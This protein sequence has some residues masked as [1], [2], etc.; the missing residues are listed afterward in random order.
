MRLPVTSYH[1]GYS[2]DRRGNSTGVKSH[3]LLPIPRWEV[4]TYHY[5]HH[6]A[7]CFA[8]DHPRGRIRQGPYPIIS[9][10]RPYPP[11]LDP[12]STWPRPSLDLP[13]VSRYFHR[14]VPYITM[15]SRDGWPFLG[16]VA[17]ATSTGIDKTSR[18]PRRPGLLLPYKRAGQGSIRG[19]HGRTKQDTSQKPSANKQRHITHR[20]TSQAIS[21]VLSLFL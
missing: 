20:S 6:T 12:S 4:K 1:H 13:S 15:V 5:I 11:V 14:L 7:H 21:L 9:G 10:I 16:H 19:T 2:C 3:F 18:L 8:T 17:T